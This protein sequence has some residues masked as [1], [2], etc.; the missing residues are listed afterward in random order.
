LSLMLKR[1]NCGGFLWKD[2]DRKKIPSPCSC[3]SFI[4]APSSQSFTPH[5]PSPNQL[6][7]PVKLH[8]SVIWLINKIGRMDE[9]IQVSKNT[10]TFF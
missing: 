2:N 5:R 4:P 7:I 9:T 3:S 8:Y 1:C 6:H 10:S